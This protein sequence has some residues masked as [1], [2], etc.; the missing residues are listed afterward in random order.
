[1]PCCCACPRIAPAI[2]GSLVTLG[3]G[4]HRPG[5]SFLADTNAHRQTGSAVNDDAASHPSSDDDPSA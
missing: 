4:Q 2:C 3:A 1:L 5:S